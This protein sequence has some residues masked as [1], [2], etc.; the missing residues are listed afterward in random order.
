MAGW[1]ALSPILST[2]ILLSAALIAGIILY[3]YF[4]NTMQGMVNT[5]N[6]VVEQAV[7]YPGI[8]AIYV[9]I[10]NYGGA[11]VPLNNSELVIVGSG[12]VRCACTVACTEPA[13]LKPS[14]VFT[15]T[16]YGSSGE[17]SIPACNVTC[18]GIDACLP[19]LE[20]GDAY[21]IFEYPYAGS[22]Q[23]T[24]PVSIALG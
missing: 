10:R 6:P 19:A 15:A 22:L 13:S 12:G 11:P 23:S 3:T 14:G 9:K 8:G 16:I 21:I 4:S 7:Y 17:T 5:P 24:Q 18:S 1:R 20:S 2:M